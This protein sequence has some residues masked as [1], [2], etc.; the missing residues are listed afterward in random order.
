[1]AVGRILNEKLRVG[2]V[3]EIEC[4]ICKQTYF[5]DNSDISLNGNQ[6]FKN[7]K[8]CR[9]HRLELKRKYELHKSIIHNSL[10][11]FSA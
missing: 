6:Y 7:C 1:M 10:I 5:P 2:V 4:S 9:K 11:N 8:Q 3:T